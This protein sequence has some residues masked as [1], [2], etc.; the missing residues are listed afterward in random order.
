LRTFIGFGQSSYIGIPQSQAI[1]LSGIA[2]VAV[3]LLFQW[4]SYGASTVV[5]N[6]NVLVD[7]RTSNCKALDQIRSVYIDNLGSD[8]PMYVYFPDTAYT[9]AAKPNSEGWYPVMT[10]S[11]VMWVIGEG[12]FTGDIPQTLIHVSNI[13]FVPSVNA[14]IDNAVAL[15]RASPLI[16]RGT[17]I[18]SSNLGIPALGD[19]FFSSGLLDFPSLGDIQNLWNTPKLTGFLY[20][21]TL[22]VNCVFAFM[23]GNNQLGQIVIES[24]GVAGILLVPNFYAEKSTVASPSNQ[25]LPITLTGIQLKLDATQTWRMRVAVPVDQGK[26]Q[27]FSS[28]TYQP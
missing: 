13:P 5:P 14:E 23:G 12:F 22:N 10:N 2:G 26:V 18:Y 20:I 19:Q 17:S 25:P 28:F 6:I 16:T 24:T 7:M 1:K 9:V 8:C 27:A 21:T 15:W 11:K 3:P 4:I